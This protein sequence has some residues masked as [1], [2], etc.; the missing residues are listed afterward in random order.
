GFGLNPSPDPPPRRERGKSRIVA[1]GLKARAPKRGALAC[2]LKREVPS[3]GFLQDRGGTMSLQTRRALAG[4]RQGPAGRR[5][6]RKRRL[7]VE[8]LESR[9]L[10][11]PFLV[12]NHQ[13]HGPG[14][15]AQAILD[16]NAAGGGN[17]DFNFNDIGTGNLTIRGP[18]PDIT[19]PV[20]IDG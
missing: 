16:S 9:R 17:I 15:L 4:E 13:D 8:A 10:L 14:S 1:S 11:A 19:R 12:T 18:L 2:A 3:A 6:R 7:E 5:A 20:T